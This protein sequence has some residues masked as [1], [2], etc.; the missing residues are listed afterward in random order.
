MLISNAV[1]ESLE[2]ISSD[3]FLYMSFMLLWIYFLY[4]VIMKMRKKELPLEQ[5]KVFPYVVMYAALAVVFLGLGLVGFLT[6][7]TRKEYPLHWSRTLN[8]ECWFLIFGSHD[9][10]HFCS[11]F[12]VLFQSLALYHLDDG[13]P[14]MAKALVF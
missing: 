9:V 4:Y 8:T 1:A 7:A 2:A 6:N 3:L 10:W 14:V 13:A 12:T 5:E 11:A